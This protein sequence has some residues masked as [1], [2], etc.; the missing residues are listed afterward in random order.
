M[1]GFTL[2]WV[3]FPDFVSNLHPF[4]VFLHHRK[5]SNP[6]LIEL[7]KAEQTSLCKELRSYAVLN[8]SVNQGIDSFKNDRLF[9]SA[10]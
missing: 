1:I 5:Q 7:I 10:L 2:V 3:Q 4:S 8:T 6:F 9:K